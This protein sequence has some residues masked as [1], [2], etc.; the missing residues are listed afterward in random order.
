MYEPGQQ[1]RQSSVLLCRSPN[2]TLNYLNNWNSLRHCLILSRQCT[3]LKYIFKLYEKS[4]SKI[5]RCPL[6]SLDSSTRSVRKC[7]D[8]NQSIML[9][10]CTSIL[11]QWEISELHMLDESQRQVSRASEQSRV[12][13]T[14]LNLNLMDLRTKTTP[15]CPRRPSCIFSSMREHYKGLGL[16][17]FLLYYT[18]F[19]VKT[20]TETSQANFIHWASIYPVIVH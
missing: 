18:T 20:F 11:S 5:F 9:Y 14:K 15:R 1:Y 16:S 2:L 7:V 8:Q 19:T 4:S 17:L 13:I 3:G 10:T 6:R 12:I